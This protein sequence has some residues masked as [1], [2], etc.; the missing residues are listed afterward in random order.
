MVEEIARQLGIEACLEFDPEVL[1]PEEKIRAFCYE[2]KCGSYQ[3]NYMCPPYTGSVEE[4]ETKLRNYK[5]GALLQY[6][7]SLDVRGD[8]EGVRQTKLDFH[9]KILQ[10]E[11]LLRERGINQVWGMIGGSCE[12]C[13][14]CKART[15][16]PCPFPNKARTSLEALAIDVVALL[17]RF[18][19]DSRFHQDRIT[20]T[21]CILLP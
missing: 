20:W 19:L 6:S 2:N 8:R 3:G 5:S 13:D 11:E 9:N 14:A 16:E 21:G 10:I 12:F 4:I 7:K 17:D 1:V 15:G 18:G